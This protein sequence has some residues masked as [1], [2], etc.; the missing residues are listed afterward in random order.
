VSP[1]T[2]TRTLNTA[3][4]WPELNADCGPDLRTGKGVGSV[5]GFILR[6]RVKVR[7][8]VRVKIKVRASSSIVPYCGSTVRI[9]PVAPT[10][11]SPISG[12]TEQTK[13]KP[14]QNVDKKINKN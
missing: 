13:I 4:I 7:V 3:Y 2:G 14:R 11:R 5:L 8:S 9:L 10:F 12:K 6:V 1:G